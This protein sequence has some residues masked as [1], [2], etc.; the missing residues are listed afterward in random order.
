[1]TFEPLFIFSQAMYLAGIFSQEYIK[2][3]WCHILQGLEEVRHLYK[4]I[5]IF[6]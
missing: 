1:M 5:D 4:Y 3:P 2:D 6:S